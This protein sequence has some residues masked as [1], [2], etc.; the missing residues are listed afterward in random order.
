MERVRGAAPMGVGSSS[1]SDGS[2]SSKSSSKGTAVATG[3]DATRGRL[4]VSW[5]R[6]WHVPEKSF[7]RQDAP[8]DV[9]RDVRGTSSD[10][11]SVP[12]T[13]QGRPQGHPWDVHVMSPGRTQ[14]RRRGMPLACGRPWDVLGTSPGTPPCF[15]N[16]RRWCT[17]Y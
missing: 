9:P 12:G 10:V 11:P 13:S 7:G 8:G 4:W 6:S 5:G 17:C 15:L 16:Q 2:S 1:D 14:G 3:P